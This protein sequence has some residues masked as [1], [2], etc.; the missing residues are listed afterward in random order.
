MYTGQGAVTLSSEWLIRRRKGRQIAPPYLPGSVTEMPPMPLEEAAGLTAADVVH[1]RF[2]AL[3]ATVTVAQVR[4][5]FDESSHRN[6]AVLADD[7]RYI[8]SINREEL[9]GEE[10]PLRPAAELSRFEPTVAPEDSA[11]AAHDLAVATPALRVPVV[12][13]DGALVG[14]VGITGDLAGFCGTR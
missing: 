4:E 10:D 3:P 2:T 1:R 14:V 5:W 9:M 6:L 8:G 13:R 7:G 11:Q 12:D